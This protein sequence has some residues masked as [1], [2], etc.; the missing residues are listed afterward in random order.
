VFTVLPH[1]VLRYRQMRPEVARDA[2]LA[3]HGGLSLELC[4]V[5]YHLSP[6]ALYRL[7]CAFGH[8]SLVTVLT[9]CGLPLRSCTSPLRIIV[10]PRK[11]SKMPPI[12]PVLEGAR[13]WS[14][15]F[16]IT[17][18]PCWHSYGSSFCRMSLGPS[19][20]YSLHPCQRSPSAHAPP[21][22][23]RL[24]ASRTGLPVLCVSKRPC[25]PTHLPQC[26]PLPC[27]QRTDA[28]GR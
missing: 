26:R 10:S 5:L 13:P 17:N 21:S 28:P 7:L 8:H 3:T 16:F 11:P 12:Q 1:F 15:T 2:L 9:R 20:V 27:P 23:N 14:H 25:V 6:M 24:R 19:Q 4:A 22:P 18:S